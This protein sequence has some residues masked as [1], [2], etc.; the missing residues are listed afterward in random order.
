VVLRGKKRNLLL[1]YL[2]WVVHLLN[3]FVNIFEFTA[4]RQ[5]YALH[6]DRT[7]IREIRLNKLLYILLFLS[8]SFFTER[9]FAPAFFDNLFSNGI[10]HSLLLF[11]FVLQHPIE[12]EVNELLVRDQ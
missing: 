4:I 7:L 5:I 6:I 3:S 10:V 1:D 2:V 8:V 11:V 9:H 12:V